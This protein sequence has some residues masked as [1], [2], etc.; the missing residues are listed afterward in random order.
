MVMMQTGEREHKLSPKWKGPFRVT[1]ILNN[2]QVQYVEMGHTREANILYCKKFFR[3]DN[4]MSTG[5]LPPVSNESGRGLINAG[6]SSNLE[7]HVSIAEMAAFRK[8][9]LQTGRRRFVVA[10][11]GDLLRLL[12][13]TPFSDDTPLCIKGHRSDVTTAQALKLGRDFAS[14]FERSAGRAAVLATRTTWGSL[15]S[16]FGDRSTEEGG[17]CDAGC[18]IPPPKVEPNMAT[19]PH[20]ARMASSGHSVPL[21]KAERPELPARDLVTVSGHSPLPQRDL[22][23]RLE[24]RL[25]R[26]ASHSPP[27][28]WTS[29]EREE[30]FE[31]LREARRFRHYGPKPVTPDP[32]REHRQRNLLLRDEVPPSI[33]GPLEVFRLKDTLRWR[34]VKEPERYPLIVRW[35]KLGPEE[36]PR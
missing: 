9:V 21:Y 35:A 8:L 14:L 4:L 36:L 22:S 30:L 27:P 19:I 3:D 17:V 29:Q 33:S 28:G 1:K 32:V 13:K 26:Q 18:T 6:S 5:L 23:K 31:A 11:K 2:F 16:R 12:R 24:K 34:P 25:T 10:K 15:K 7:S 20:L